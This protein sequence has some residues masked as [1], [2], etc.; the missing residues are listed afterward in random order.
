MNT[1]AATKK[2]LGRILTLF[3]RIF[4]KASRITAR[5]LYISGID[6][7]CLPEGLPL[8][9]KYI[10]PMRVSNACGKSF[11]EMD[12]SARENLCIDAETGANMQY[13]QEV[14]R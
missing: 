10:P 12:A 11:E 1:F 14:S 7:F 13:Y 5:E 4:L 2:N 9:N 3:D 8:N 6:I